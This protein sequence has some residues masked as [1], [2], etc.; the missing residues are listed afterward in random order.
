MDWW[1]DMGIWD[2]ETADVHDPEVLRATNPVVSRVGPRGHTVSYQQLARD[3]VRLMGRLSDVVDGH[4]ITDDRVAEYLRNADERS[5]GLRDSIDA[6]IE[7][8]GLDTAEPEADP[9]DVSLA[10]G[11]SVEFLTRLNLE[12]A[13]VGAVV[14]STGFTADFSWIDLPVVDEHG[15]PQHVKGVSNAP[16]VY[17]VGFPWLSKRR[18]GVIFGV[19]E[20]AR[21]VTDT[22][23]GQAQVS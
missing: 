11:E 20:D 5:L 9:A 21:Y 17:F 14:W 10:A 7:E 1:L 12:E 19:D 4:L 8:H 23:V 6:F 22:I 18:S 3:G 2:I 15:T 13:G 16:G